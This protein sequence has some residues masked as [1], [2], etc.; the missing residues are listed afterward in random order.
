MTIPLNSNSKRKSNTKRRGGEIKRGE[1]ATEATTKRGIRVH[2]H[3]HVHTVNKG[4][5]PRLLPFLLVLLL[6]LLLQQPQVVH[7]HTDHVNPELVPP[8]SEDAHDRGFVR[9]TEDAQ[10]TP[11]AQ[12]GNINIS[13]LTKRVLRLVLMP[14]SVDNPFFD[15]SGD[16][17]R[18]A[19]ALLSTTN[20]DGIEVQCN[21]TGPPADADDVAGELQA[22]MVRELVA[23]GE[24]DALAIAVRSVEVVGPAIQEAVA[25]NIPVV[26]FD[27]DAPDSG[28]LCYIGTDNYVSTYICHIM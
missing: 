13:P 19:A 16:G 3:E 7:S 2:A 4:S 23:S 1:T 11:N 26:T 28:R 25:A 27:S 14:K 17:C 6:M 9:D 12:A 20:S 22:Q 24:M 15:P 5:S 10:A 8:H 21:Y 18:D